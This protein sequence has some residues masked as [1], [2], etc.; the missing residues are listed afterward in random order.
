MSA[1]K[2]T[3]TKKKPVS[4]KVSRRELIDTGTQQAFCPPECPGHVL[5][6][7]SR[8]WPVHSAG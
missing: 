7:G 1:R 5:R 3:A 2:K 8:C 4:Q 6:K